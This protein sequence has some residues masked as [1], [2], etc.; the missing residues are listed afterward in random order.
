MMG[1]GQHGGRRDPV[2]RLWGTLGTGISTPGNFHNA[3]PLYAM[4]SVD[5]QQIFW[6]LNLEVFFF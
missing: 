4:L 6:F 5:F 3:A 1:N 2:N